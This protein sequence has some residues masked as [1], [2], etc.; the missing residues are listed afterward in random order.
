MRVADTCS[1]IGALVCR[2]LVTPGVLALVLRI[3]IH[4][5]SDNCPNCLGGNI[6]H[7]CHAIPVMVEAVQID[8]VACHFE[9]RLGNDPF[10]KLLVGRTSSLKD[11]SSC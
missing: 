11:S 5:Y 9:G 10:N 3:V 8:A 6:L 7:L 4:Q 2:G 1:V